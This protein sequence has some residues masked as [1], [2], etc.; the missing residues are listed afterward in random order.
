MR[1]VIQRGERG[2]GASAGLARAR[3]AGDFDEAEAA[4]LQN[5]E[6]FNLGILQREGQRKNFEGAAVH[7]YEAGGRV[8][9]GPSQNGAQYSAEKGDAQGTCPTTGKGRGGAVQEARPDDHFAA[10]A[11]E[12][13]E[14]LG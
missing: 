14:H 2:D 7:S 8:M 13:F 3:A 11:L 1:D 4:A 6:G 12:S 10:F 9:H 5:N